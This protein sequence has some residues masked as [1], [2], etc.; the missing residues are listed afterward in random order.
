MITESAEPTAKKTTLTTES[1]APTSSGGIFGT[2]LALLRRHK[3]FKRFT[4]FAIVGALGFVIDAGTVNGLLTL[5]WLENVMLRLPFGLPEITEIGIVGAIG[6]TCAV[7]SNFLWNRFW[8][9]PDS[10]TKP[11]AGQ[12]V[13]FFFVNIVGLIIR[14]PVLEGLNRPLARLIEAVL[15]FLGAEKAARLG[16]NAALVTAVLIVMFWNFFVNRYW[17]Y[18]DV[19]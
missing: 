7:T 4:K 6:F 12:L 13:T 2:L 17:T 14:I 19:E 5:G 8:T 1:P 10:R 9:Y 18:N 16:V 11:V 3:E 15:P